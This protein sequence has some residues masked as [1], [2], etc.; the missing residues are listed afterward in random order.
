MAP[1][2]RG[3]HSAPLIPAKSGI[4]APCGWVTR[5]TRIRALA[6][7]SAA[8]TSVAP[9]LAATLPDPLAAGWK[10]EKVCAV[11]QETE[12]LRMLKCSF[13]PGAGHERHFH[14]PHTGYILE[15]G[16]MRITDANGVRE[17]DNLP[18]GSWKSGGIAWH[19]ALNVGETTTVYIIVEDKEPAM[20]AGGFDAALARHLKA[21]ADRD[22]AAFRASVTAG[23]ALYTIVQN[24]HA[25]TTPAETIGLHAEWFARDDWSWRG[26]VVQKIIGS[27]VGVALIRYRYQ[28]SKNAA[29]ISTW[30]TLVFRI[31]NGAWRLV[32]DQN[33]MIALEAAQ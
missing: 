23:P 7:M 3:Q 14:A 16:R 10:S 5:T 2:S 8:I 11:L 13:A 33:T 19:E 28:D 32:L 27:D 4:H 30:L 26:E 17:L 21:I 12:K 24:G 6:G 29:P 22:L 9:A 1:M 20:T 18:G 25:F 15:G 31:E